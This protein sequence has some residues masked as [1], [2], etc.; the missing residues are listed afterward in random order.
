MRFIAAA[1][2]FVNAFRCIAPSTRGVRSDVL[3]ISS[4][5]RDGRFAFTG[6]PADRYTVGASKPPYLGAIAG[7]KRPGRPGVPVVLANGQQIT[8]VA[9]RLPLGA[10]ISGVITD[11]RG[12]PAPSTA[13]VLH[14]WKMQG[15]ER[16]LV[17]AA[18]VTTDDRGGEDG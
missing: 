10:A 4:T 9:I 1:P 15:T 16:A 8:N 7:A 12:R 3:K 6:L 5:D 14:Q 2:D 11:E 17:Q 18:S 13:A